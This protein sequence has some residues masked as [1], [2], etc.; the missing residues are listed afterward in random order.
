MAATSGN[1]PIWPVSHYFS[2]V[3]NP[4]TVMRPFASKFFDHLFDWRKA[5]HLAYEK[6][7][8]V[9]PKVVFWNKWGKKTEIS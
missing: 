8:S 9:I 1:A 2:I 6:P 4:S 5:G 3:K 7:V